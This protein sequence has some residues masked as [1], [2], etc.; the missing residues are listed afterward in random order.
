MLVN[1]LGRV[2]RCILEGSAERS[3]MTSIKS[4]QMSKKQQ[5]VKAEVK[6]RSR[7]NRK[8]LMMLS[9]IIHGGS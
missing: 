1:S 6:I 4:M 9:V 8:P 7:S 2:E 3:L 5:K